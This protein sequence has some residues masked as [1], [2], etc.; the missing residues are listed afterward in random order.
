MSLCLYTTIV[1]VCVC[2]SLTVVVV[3]AKGSARKSVDASRLVGH[4]STFMEARSC[5]GWLSNNARTIAKYSHA[6][7]D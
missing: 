7:N 6:I 5:N 4:N 2:C 1:C 3:Y